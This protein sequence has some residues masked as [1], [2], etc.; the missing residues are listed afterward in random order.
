VLRVNENVGVFSVEVGATVG[1]LSL[2]VVG[3]GPFMLNGD[4][5][6]VAVGSGSGLGTVTRYPYVSQ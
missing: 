3:V 5:V 2:V 6:G 4:G 1:E